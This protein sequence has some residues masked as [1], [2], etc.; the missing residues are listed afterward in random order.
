MGRLLTGST[1]QLLQSSCCAA[2]SLSPA[3]R[4]RGAGCCT[5][6]LP[7]LPARCP[8]PIS[9]ALGKRA[10]FA[11]E[12]LWALPFFSRGTQGGST[13]WKTPS[14]LTPQQPLGLS[15]GGRTQDTAWFHCAPMSGEL[16]PR[17][18]P[19]PACVTFLEHAA[20]RSVAGPGVPTSAHSGPHL[21]QS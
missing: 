10:P 7:R 21:A 2:T 12:K 11:K 18:T 1:P 4:Q 3:G 19:R 9:G 17:V 6:H 13:P 16:G 14:Q 15:L 5:S 20:L 8:G